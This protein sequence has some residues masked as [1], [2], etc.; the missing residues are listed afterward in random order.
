[1]KIHLEMTN[2]SVQHIVA[3]LDRFLGAEIY[4]FNVL[5]RELLFRFDFL[6]HLQRFLDYVFVIVII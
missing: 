4:N 3:K 5:F 6:N 2:V 1:M